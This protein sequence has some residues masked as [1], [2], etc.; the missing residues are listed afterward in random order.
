MAWSV[1]SGASLTG[2][3]V[4]FTRTVKVCTPTSTTR[5]RLLRLPYQFASLLAV[6]V[7]PLPSVVRRTR[8]VGAGEIVPSGLVTSACVTVTGAVGV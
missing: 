6:M 2:R 4:M 8:E 5:F 1:P 3:T 7:I